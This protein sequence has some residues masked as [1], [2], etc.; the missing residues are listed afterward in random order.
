MGRP[1]PYSNHK[2][3]Q[4]I[5]RQCTAHRCSCEECVAGT[6]W[7]VLKSKRDA[8]EKI[9]LRGKRRKRSPTT[10]I[11]LRFTA[12]NNLRPS[13]FHIDPPWTTLILPVCTHLSSLI[14]Y[15]ISSF[16]PTRYLCILTDL[17]RWMGWGALLF[18][19][20]R[21]SLAH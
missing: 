3:K 11:P 20:I 21:L 6:R 18:S 9:Y 15:C 1:R 10:L 12:S 2:E 13:S 19:R 8:K 7:P 14:L 4:K 16:T 5:L 17:N